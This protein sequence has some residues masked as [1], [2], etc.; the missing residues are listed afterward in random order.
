[1]LLFN[2][3]LVLNLLFSLTETVA[4]SFFSVK[5]VGEEE[6]KGFASEW[7]FKALFLAVFAVNF[8][9]QLVWDLL[10]YPYFVD[11]LRYVPRAPVSF[12]ISLLLGS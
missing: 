1:M 12:S 8:A 10:I 2:E 11:S 5:A 3:E 7:S 4:I 9:L 6:T